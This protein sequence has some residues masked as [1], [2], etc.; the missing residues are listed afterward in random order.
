M[1]DLSWGLIGCGDIARKRVAAALRNAPGSR[2]HAV[3]SRQA[4]QAQAFA[5]AHEAARTF[6]DWRE[7]VREPELDAV[8]VA[9]PVSLHA[10]Q[11]IAAAEAGKHVLCEKPMA[12]HVADCDRMISAAQASGVRL[13]VAYYRR[14]Y[15]VVRRIAELLD[16]GEFGKPVLAQLTAFERFDCKPGEARSW[17]L[18]P[19]RSGGGPMMDF[20]AHRLELLLN[21]FGPVANVSGWTDSLYFQDRP[22]EDT[23]SADLRFA[24]GVRAQ[25]TVSHAAKEPRDVVDIYCSGGSLHVPELSGGELR[26]WRSDSE[27][28]EN[29]P[30]HENLHQPLVDDFVAAVKQQRDPQVSGE[31][32][33]DTQHLLSQIYQQ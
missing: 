2:L 10:E 9:T 17:L 20:G 11:T 18:D 28:V 13:G 22:V 12:L 23:A 1:P 32:G 30:P 6:A 5:K 19:S 14:F 8:Y 15:P 33:R 21:L 24:S 16:S 25:L 31:D 27:R 29:L 3:A 26:I 7:L 4:D